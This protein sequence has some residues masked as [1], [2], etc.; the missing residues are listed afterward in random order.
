MLN[1]DDFRPI[2]SRYEKPIPIPATDPGATPGSSLTLSCEWWSY[3][4]G[5]VKHMQDQGV[6]NTSDPAVMTSTLKKV[7]H[8][9]QLITFSYN[10]K[11]EKP[12]A[13][14][15]CH[16]TDFD[17]TYDFTAS[18]ANPW[19]AVD[20][21]DMLGNPAWSSGDGWVG[22]Y[23]IPFFA[24]E[25]EV[26]IQ[27]DFIPQ[28]VS[29]IEFTQP[30]GTFPSDSLEGW[31][32]RVYDHGLHLLLEV[33]QS[34]TLT[35]VWNGLIID[36]C[37][38]QLRSFLETHYETIDEIPVPSQVAEIST[39]NI[40]G[41]STT[42]SCEQEVPLADPP[43]FVDAWCNFYD[44]TASE[45][46]FAAYSGHAY[47]EAGV[48]WRETSVGGIVAATIY[49]DYSGL[50]TD[51]EADYDVSNQNGN[52]TDNVAFWESGSRVLAN[53]LVHSDGY[54]GTGQFLAAHGSHTFDRILITGEAHAGGYWHWTHLTVR[55]IGVNPD[56]DFAC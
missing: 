40:I 3:L 23:N 37:R 26:I 28:V 9:M 56:P 19:I 55:G 41:S 48:G 29:H 33:P 34:L 1:Y 2:H 35:T 38:I 36:A 39:A 27:A 13:A 5:A 4:A 18:Q 11:T 43:E 10:K 49:K 15:G 22:N 54:S 52:D 8:L 14:P 30:S 20:T 16:F 25:S 17:C 42:G 32:I 50:G 44:F 21:P 7:D 53:T 24:T 47:Y 46:G 12:E 45:C 31:A 51:I 6:W